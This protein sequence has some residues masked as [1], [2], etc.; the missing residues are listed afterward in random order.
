MTYEQF[1]QAIHEA[2]VRGVSEEVIEEARKKW[3]FEQMMR[4][5]KHKFDI[6]RASEYLH[7]MYLY[8][9]EEVW[10]AIGPETEAQYFRGL[11][12]LQEMIEYKWE[13]V[14]KAYAK[15]KHYEYLEEQ[16]VLSDDEAYQ[17]KKW[18]TAKQAFFAM[19]KYMA[20]GALAERVNRYNVLSTGSRKVNSRVDKVA[21]GVSPARYRPLPS[22][23]RST[24]STLPEDQEAIAI[25]R[26]YEAK[27]EGKLAR[28][29]KR[30]KNK[31][32][33]E[34]QKGKK[35]Q[36]KVVTRKTDLALVRNGMGLKFKH[37][38]KSRRK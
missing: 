16:K 12:S 33:V 1:E 28:Y 29:F 32:R 7:L 5:D 36:T 17:L 30:H 2:R 6:K 14:H 25:I 23:M 10:K 31:V 3:K 37:I 4:D 18:L 26:A 9:D 34:V 22:Y 15:W 38:K 21:G 35:K 20:P 13:S 19:K 27:T 24:G 8:I 11:R